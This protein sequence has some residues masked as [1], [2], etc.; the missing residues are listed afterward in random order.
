M[1][2]ITVPNLN[3]CSHFLLLKRG[4]HFQQNAHKIFHNTLN[5]LLCYLVK[6]IVQQY[7]IP[8]H[9]KHTTDT[10]SVHRNFNG[11][12]TILFGDAADRI[13]HCVEV[14]KI[15]HLSVHLWLTRRNELSVAC[16]LAELISAVQYA[17]PT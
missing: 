11:I 16:A 7:C 2:A 14:A 5:V 6:Q 4:L 8:W 13:V 9:T 3:G 17:H 15:R 12:Q 10:A 1:L